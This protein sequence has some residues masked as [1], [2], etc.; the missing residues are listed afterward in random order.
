MKRSSFLIILSLALF[1]GSSVAVSG[2]RPK[3]SNV[4]K[5]SSSSG[6]GDV[7]SQYRG[8]NRDGVSHSAT[9]VNAW[10]GQTPKLLWKQAIGDGFSG[11]L[12]AKDHLLTAFA[13]DS[14]EFLA[15]FDRVTGKER[16]R[17]ELGKMFV[18]DFGNGPR[19]T[20]TLDG[21]RVFA[22]GSYGDLYAVA[23]QSGQLLWTFSL[24]DELEVKA[25]RRGFTT[26]PF[27][28]KGLVIV[29]AGGGEGEA[30]VALDKESG[31]IAWKAG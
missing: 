16:W 23:V 17:L 3:S 2:G 26:S 10:S 27:V 21:D 29:Q 7:W 1:A 19:S 12:V 28:Q 8:P 30:F 11:I 13:V 22:L 4:S 6:A 18:D 31:K 25:P 9:T 20:P 14:T 24:A 5:A 15:S